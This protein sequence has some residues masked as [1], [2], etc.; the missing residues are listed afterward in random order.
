MTA[1][2]HL[3]VTHTRENTCAELADG[4]VSGTRLFLALSQCV[5]RKKRL[6]F[7]QALNTA[8][9]TL[10]WHLIRLGPAQHAQLTRLAQAS[11]FTDPKVNAT[12]YS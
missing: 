3:T 12:L 10:G 6:V 9:L 4:R 2:K 5:Q 8:V 1:C 7:Y 11:G